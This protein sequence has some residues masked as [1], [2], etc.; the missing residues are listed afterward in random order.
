[1]ITPR[2]AGCVLYRFSFSAPDDYHFTQVYAWV[3]AK[4]IDEIGIPVDKGTIPKSQ[5]YF[6]RDGIWE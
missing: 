4:G 5:L 1:M 6:L 3:L 2:I